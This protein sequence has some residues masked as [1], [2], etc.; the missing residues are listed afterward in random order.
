MAQY[1]IVVVGGGHNG[2]VAAAY[3]AKAGK[4]VI[5]LEAKPFF[6]GGVV[7]RELTV[8]GFKH[9]QHS[10][11]HIMLQANPLI[12]N[13]EL[14]LKSKFGL[15]YNFPKRP[16]V[17]IFED[18]SSISMFTDPAANVA[19]I[20]RFSAEDAQAYAEV[21]ALGAKLLPMLTAGMFVP[22][23]PF[24][25]TFAM[26]DQS[27]E[28]RVML[29]IL[30]RS[31][32]D[33][34]SD[35][36]KNEKVRM[37][38][39]KLLSENLAAPFERGT[40]IGLLFFVAAIE[41]YGCGAAVGGSGELSRAL[42]D[43]IKSHGG[44]I[45]CDTPVT[46]LIVSGGR[47]TGVRTADNEEIMARDAVIGAIHPHLLGRFIDGLDTGVVQR[48]ERVQQAAYSAFAVHAA[49]N[50]P[51]RFK[52]DENVDDGYVVELHSGGMEDFLRKFDDMKYG[53]LPKK[54][55]IGASSPSVADT[56]RV[57]EG[58][59]TFYAFS[60]AP[61]ELADG[62]AAAW[63]R[64]KEQHQQHII[65][66]IGLFC[67]NLDADNIIAVHSDSPLDLERSSPS[68]QRGDIHGC[69][70]YLNQFAAHRP[71]PD[72]GNYTVPGVERM[73]LVG[74]FLHPGGGVFGA[75]RG[76]AIRMFDDLGMDFDKVIS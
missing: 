72:L 52:S 5:V 3:L 57:P 32:W 20:A 67:H 53:H 25:A 64:I 41:R 16:F 19:E 12:V 69:A 36:F 33:L 8:P 73:Y 58:K 47:A 11:S 48:A 44:E 30:Q 17:S 9:D 37:H 14:G 42:A 31:A 34:V 70:P 18:G 50:E 74:P 40:G 46:K 60:Y 51:L 55:L 63:D 26:L 13:D 27:L 28:G 61:Y 4:Q 66:E 56:T 29:D 23:A 68:F 54:P 45:R 75:G 15:K 24:G 2:L 59:A 7:T 62:G 6:G 39:L 21:S 10:M 49:L 76:T 1:D 35:R 71:T 38:F 65:E 43:C 22:P